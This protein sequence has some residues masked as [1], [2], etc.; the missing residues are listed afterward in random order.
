MKTDNIKKIIVLSTFIFFIISISNL[1]VMTKTKAPTK[2][3]LLNTGMAKDLKYMRTL[4]NNIKKFRDKSRRI[5]AQAESLVY[6][7][8]NLLE[9]CS[10]QN[11]ETDIPLIRS[12][13][14]ALGFI[15]GNI[16]THTKK[17]YYVNIDGLKSTSSIKLKEKTRIPFFLLVRVLGGKLDF[18]KIIWNRYIEKAVGRLSGS[19]KVNDIPPV[20]SANSFPDIFTGLTRVPECKYYIKMVENEKKRSGE[21]Q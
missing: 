10:A 1:P 15:L 2:T 21:C 4:L 5:V 16:R 12:K 17:F 13:M 20:C 14:T 6:I 19:S 7:V 11:P 3:S 9:D 18:D 8:N